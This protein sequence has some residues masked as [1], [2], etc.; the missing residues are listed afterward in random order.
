LISFRGPFPESAQFRI[1]LPDGLH[2]DGG[3]MLTNAASFP[4]TVKTD[5]MPPLAKFSARFGIIERAD[6]IL[7]V[8]MRNLE[9]QVATGVLRTQAGP[10]IEPGWIGA[11]Q[12]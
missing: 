9:A 2:D 7:P 6:P 11:I 4:I 1:S 12:R 10:K 8:T 5:A 3:R